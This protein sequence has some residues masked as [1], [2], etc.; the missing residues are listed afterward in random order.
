[1]IKMNQKEINLHA[2]KEVYTDIILFLHFFVYLIK[3][4]YGTRGIN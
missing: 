1:M 4:V 3:T 2:I